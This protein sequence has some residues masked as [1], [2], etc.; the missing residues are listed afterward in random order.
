MNRIAFVIGEKFLYWNSII[1]TLAVLSAI[2]MFWALAVRN[3]EDVKVA[4]IAVPVAFML[5]LLLS[6]LVHWYC[7]PQGYEGILSA[8]L[9][10]SRGSFALIGVF[11]GC[12]LTAV[13]LRIFHVSRNLPRLLDQMCLA[14]ALGIAVGRPAALFTTADRGIPVPQWVPFP[15]ASRLINSVS[16][17]TEVRL[18]VFM[19]QAF[20]AAVL[21][22]CLL[23]AYLRGRKK[24]TLRDGDTCLL[25]LLWYCGT[26]AVL[27]SP[28]YDSLYFRSNGFVSVVQIFG[29]LTVILTMIIFTVR[30]I[31]CRRWSKFFLPFLTF[32][33]LGLA[34][35]M[36]YHVQRH[37]SQ[38]LFAY[39]VMSLSMLTAL[40]MILRIR[41]N[42]VPV[43]RYPGYGGTLNGPYG[44]QQ[45][46]PPYNTSGS[47][48][49]FDS[50]TVDYSR[51][52]PPRPRTADFQRPVRENGTAGRTKKGRYQGKYAANR[53]K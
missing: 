47:S 16:G 19:F 18:A 48:Y 7:R 39:S 36:E 41:A 24:E 23:I 5:S 22:V 8:L 13:L 32:P 26:Q 37:G 49:D 28:R 33:L 2:C 29:I 46:H 30:L 1:L 20:V 6:R 53:K 25:F 15:L 27:D 50:Q 9:D 52:Q 4:V 44:G 10:Y 40:I 21:F 11:A 35:Y 43:K 51:P 17:E 42:A 38:A 12:L 31:K 14:G 34:G 45:P 3:R